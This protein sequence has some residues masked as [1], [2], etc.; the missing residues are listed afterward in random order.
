MRTYQKPPIGRR[1]GVGVGT[2]QLLKACKGTCEM[3]V[4]SP[5]EALFVES[6]FSK[7]SIADFYDKLDK[8]EAGRTFSIDDAAHGGLSR[9]ENGMS[10]K[11]E[12]IVAVASAAC[13]RKYELLRQKG[14]ESRSDLC[15]V[16]RYKLG[17]ALR[18]IGV[19][20]VLGVLQTQRAKEIDLPIVIY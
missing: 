12:S 10:G 20:R 8:D 3:V 17:E 11:G 2:D 19:Q 9:I 4:C 14:S 18:H 15:C 7:G 13:Q 16:W 6:R 1:Y 5:S